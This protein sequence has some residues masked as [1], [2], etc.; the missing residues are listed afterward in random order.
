MISVISV[1]GSCVISVISVIGGWDVMI[2][3]VTATIYM[4]CI[5]RD[6]KCRAECAPSAIEK[7]EVGMGGSCSLRLPQRSLAASCWTP[8]E[9]PNSCPTSID[10]IFSP[11]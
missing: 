1:V 4:W 8:R 9:S 6:R 7:G 5:A 3:D 2:T 11:C 10:R